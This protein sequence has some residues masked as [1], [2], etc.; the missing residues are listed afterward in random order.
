LELLISKQLGAS[1]AGVAPSDDVEKYRDAATRP[2]VKA[3]SD[4]VAEVRIAAATDLG[5]VGKGRAQVPIPELIAALKDNSAGVRAAA[6]GSLGKLIPGS[7]SMVPV[8]LSMMESD[9]FVVRKAIVAALRSARPTPALVPVL[10]VSLQR[11]DRQVR[12]EVARLLG[13]IA[14]QAEAAVPSLIALLSEPRDQQMSQ[15]RVSATEWDPACRAAIALG[16]IAPSEQGI[17]ALT[18]MLSSSSPE[19]P[20]NPERRLCAAEALGRIGP[21]AVTAAPALIAALNALLDSKQEMPGAYAMAV[22][23]GQL[24]RGSD[25]AVDAVAT[26]NRVLGSRYKLACVAAALALTKFGRTAFP[27]LPNLRALA[28]DPSSSRQIRDAARSAVDAIGR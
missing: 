2:L 22:A 25:S 23:C 6:V 15:T 16:R 14:A 19:Q 7:D 21:R 5:S 28:A 9:E 17:A 12:F 13:A 24:A 20:G 11:P 27:A 1:G 18:A 10:V 4:Q 8:F 26:L 3:L